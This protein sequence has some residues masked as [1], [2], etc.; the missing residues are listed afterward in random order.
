MYN[1]N[2][3]FI[4]IKMLCTNSKYSKWKLLFF[5]D[6]SD[7]DDHYYR[8]PLS[9]LVFLKKTNHHK[10][11]KQIL[12]LLLLLSAQRMVLNVVLWRCFLFSYFSCYLK[13]VLSSWMA[14]GG[15]C[16]WLTGDTLIPII[17]DEEK[18]LMVYPS[19]LASQTYRILTI[20]SVI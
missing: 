5:D 14:G 12:L 15:T 18:L 16:V 13:C 10:S 8:T 4:T 1:K 3:S 7:D 20:Y 2:T 19:Y 9:L 6:H 17:S 11:I